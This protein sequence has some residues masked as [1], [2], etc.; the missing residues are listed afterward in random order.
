MKFAL[1]FLASVCVSCS[2]TPPQ[3]GIDSDAAFWQTRASQVHEGMRRVDVERLLP[4]RSGI[5]QDG[6]GGSH[7]LL[8]ALDSHWMVCICYDHTGVPRDSSG[9]ALS[10]DSPE[11]RVLLSGKPPL[12]V[13]LSRKETPLDQLYPN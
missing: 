4:P 9:R 7:S 5:D 1:I 8:Y 11:N 6:M 12:A 10:P 13:H 3:S 2:R